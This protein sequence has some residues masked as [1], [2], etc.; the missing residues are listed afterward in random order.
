MRR[1]SECGI[2]A[3]LSSSQ[4]PEERHV[5][6]NGASLSPAKLRRSGIRSQQ[7]R[8]H[9]PLL[10]SLGMVLGV[11]F[12]RHGAPTELALTRAPAAAHWT[13]LAAAVTHFQC[14]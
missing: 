8:I 2:V 4:A 6:S 1:C 11:G 3:A 13:R 12:Y 9:M 5:Y 7:D 14:L 10:R